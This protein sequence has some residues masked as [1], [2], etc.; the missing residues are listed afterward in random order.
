MKTMKTKTIRQTV[1]FSCTPHEFYE[2]IM[3]SK[4]HSFYTGD[5]AKM[6]RKEGGEFIAAAGYIEGKNLKLVKDKMIVQS[7]RGG[8][9]PEGHMS[10]V[11]FELKK[12]KT[13]TKLTFTHEGVPEKNYKNI[14]TGWKTYYWDKIKAKL[15]NPKHKSA[16][17][18]K[19]MLKKVSKKSTAKKSAVKKAKAKK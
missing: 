16:P 3:D 15:A 1:I 17:T 9:F 13:G 5:E 14:N 4:K 19:K 6:S 2:I 8:D 12:D 18:P 10:K 11:V 7:W